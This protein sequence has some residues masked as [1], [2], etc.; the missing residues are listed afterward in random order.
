MSQR[1]AAQDQMLIPGVQCVC[2][3]LQLII[4]KQVL[5]TKTFD[6]NSKAMTITGICLSS[7]E[8]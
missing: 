4:N 6:L 8:N 1:F 7:K 3:D 2:T 5:E